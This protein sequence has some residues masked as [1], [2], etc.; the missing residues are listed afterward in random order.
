ME[1]PLYA[2]GSQATDRAS[3]ERKT[4]R[5]AAGGSGTAAAVRTSAGCECGLKPAAFLARTL[6]QYR[7][8]ARR[9]PTEHAAA[10]PC[11]GALGLL[12]LS[13]YGAS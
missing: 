1:P 12:A 6:T 3:A 7:Q 2:G 13:F 8:P 9:P 10:S 5:G 11:K 4:A